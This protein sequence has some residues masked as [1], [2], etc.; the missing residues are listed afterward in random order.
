MSGK[1]RPRASVLAGGALL[2]GVLGLALGTARATQPDEPAPSTVRRLTEAQYRNTIADIFGA[3]MKVLG[4]FDPDLRVEGLLAVGTTAASMTPAAFEHFEEIARGVS[5]Q[6]VD[7]DHRAKLVGCEPQG[8]DA[9]GARCAEAFFARVGQRLY[10]RPLSPLEARSLAAS[11]VASSQRLGDFHA[12]LAA[13]L[14]GMLTNPEFLFR[15]DAPDRSGTAVDSYSKAA[16]LS[17]FLWNTT[18]DDALLSAAASGQLDT[19]DGLANQVDRLMA[20]PRMAEGVRAFFT[21]FL[22]LDDMD[23]LSKDTLIYP[24]FSPSVAQAAREQTLRTIVDHVVT[25]DADYRDLFTTRR[26]AMTRVLGPLYDI[27]VAANGWYIHEFPAD[28]PRAGLLTQASLL[29]L[30]SHPGRTS[31][32]LRGKGLLE[33]LLCQKVPAPPANVNFA[34]VQDVD[35][36]TLKTT[37]ARLQAHLTDEECASCHKRTDPAGL[38]LEQF[39]GAGQFRTTEHGEP[40]DVSGQF[41]KQAFNGAAEFGQLLSKSP[42]ISACLVSTAW[43]YAQGREPRAEDLPDLETLKQR[44]AADGYRVTALMRAIALDPDFYA[45][46][47]TR[48]PHGAARRTAQVTK[49]RSS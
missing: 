32:T 3:D 8:Q 40:I 31:P 38:G 26:F 42:Q 13:V 47:R 35:N 16:R 46:P 1:P 39:D 33:S 45:F 17:Y 36:P 19:R 28:D 9:D 12:G 22:Q 20:S 48:P 14:A 34:V 25:R 15:I 2:A 4:R 7:A 41:E 29:A 49:G 18:P 21:D 5:A 30:H 24:A 23:T 27:P 43:R 37:R 10:R 44:F 11:A 6:V